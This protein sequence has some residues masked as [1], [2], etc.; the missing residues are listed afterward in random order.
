MRLAASSSEGVQSRLALRL[1]SFFEEVGRIRY[2]TWHYGSGL[3][4]ETC[5]VDLVPDGAQVEHSQVYDHLAAF[6]FPG[7]ARAFQALREHRLTRGFR[8]A[9][10]DRHADAAI[11]GIVHPNAVLA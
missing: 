11:V 7:H 5:G 4:V 6:G 1:R 10:A 9:A 3:G 2:T 8:Y